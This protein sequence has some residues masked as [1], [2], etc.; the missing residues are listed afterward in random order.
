MKALEPYWRP[1]M[2]AGNCSSQNRLIVSLPNRV[3]GSVWKDALA[4]FLKEK[5]PADKDIAAIQAQLLKVGTDH[6]SAD[7]RDCLVAKAT[8]SSHR[9]PRSRCLRRFSEWQSLIRRGHS[10][11]VF[12]V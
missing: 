4:E 3:P 11:V 7:D 9:R 8:G 5:S 2:E 10:N 6:R 12:A 1:A